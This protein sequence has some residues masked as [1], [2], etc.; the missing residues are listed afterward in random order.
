MDYFKSAAIQYHLSEEITPSG[1]KLGYKKGKKGNKH[2][3][4]NYSYQ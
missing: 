1:A 4:L 3:G 2:K